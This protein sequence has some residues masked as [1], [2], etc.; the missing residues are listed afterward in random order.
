M[1]SIA[2]TPLPAVVAQTPNITRSSAIRTFDGLHSQA[3]KVAGV[4]AGTCNLTL[5]QVVREKVGIRKGRV[6]CAVG[7]V[8]AAGTNY[9][10]AGA[11]AVALIGT[12]FPFIF[13]RKD[14]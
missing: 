12:A 10:I 11:V 6:V 5:K 14:T 4:K 7:D 2:V 3:G 9:L 13:S 1:A 8:S